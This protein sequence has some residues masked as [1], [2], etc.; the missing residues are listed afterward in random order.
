MKDIRDLKAWDEYVEDKPILKE[1]LGELAQGILVL[2][3]NQD[4]M[5]ERQEK[6]WADIT[7]LIEKLQDK[8]IYK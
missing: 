5:H 7:M 1:V 3:E 4:N 6:M 8:R 2:K